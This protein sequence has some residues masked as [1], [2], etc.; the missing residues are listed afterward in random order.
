MVW[1]AVGVIRPIVLYPSGLGQPWTESCSA[2]ASETALLHDLIDRVDRGRS[3]NG[4]SEAK[5][6]TCCIAT[7]AQ[8]WRE[9]CSFR[10]VL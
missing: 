3:S 9:R 7:A 8:R 1:M 10:A 2:A 4:G 5:G 6:R